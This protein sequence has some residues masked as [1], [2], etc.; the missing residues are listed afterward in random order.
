MAGTPNSKTNN[1]EDIKD[2]HSMQ[3]ALSKLKDHNLTLSKKVASL[4]EK[5]DA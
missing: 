5:V 2:I 1:N 4:K 3:E